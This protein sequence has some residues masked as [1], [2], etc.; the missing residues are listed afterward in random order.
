MTK[1]FIATPAYDGKV[2]VQYAVS[3]AETFH[4]LN[5][6]HIEC[7]MRIHAS[8]S[9][10]CAERNRLLEAFMATDCTHILCIDSDIGW[11]ANDVLALLHRDIDVAAGCY[12]ARQEK[13]FLFRPEFNENG[14]V[15]GCDK[16]KMLKMTHIPA[17]FML[18]KRQVIMDMRE[19]YPELYFK[20]KLIEDAPSGYALFETGIVDGEFWGEDYIFCS[21]LAECGFEI[22]VDPTLRFDH[23][24]NVG[25][26]IEALTDDKEKAMVTK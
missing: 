7:M 21:R 12:P 17:G 10:L 15:V 11:H 6:S 13:L 2:H 22:W 18:I 4:L 3:L 19:H 14:S 23:A 26:L 5:S 9:L 25:A 20:P 1:I 24:G 16:K 8:G